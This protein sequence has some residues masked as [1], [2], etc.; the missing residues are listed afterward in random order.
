MSNFIVWLSVHKKFVCNKVSVFD[1]YTTNVAV[2]WLALVLDI[3]GAP[4]SHL[5]LEMG[6]P[7]MSVTWLLTLE[8]EGEFERG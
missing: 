7:T 6:I 4:H 5:G 3:R 1:I 2:K 8:E